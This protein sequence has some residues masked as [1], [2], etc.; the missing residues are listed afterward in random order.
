MTS[1]KQKKNIC[2]CSVVAGNFQYKTSLLAFFFFFGKKNFFFD[3]Q[4]KIKQIF[5]FFLKL[6]NR[7]SG[8]LQQKSSLVQ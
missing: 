1:W 8:P 6:A 7:C 3:R 4:E 2:T 5:R